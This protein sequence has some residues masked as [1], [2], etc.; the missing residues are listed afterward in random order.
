MVL[1]I[2]LASMFGCTTMHTMHQPT[3]LAAKEQIQVGDEITVWTKSGRSIQLKVT[4]VSEDALFG[5]FKAD[6]KKYKIPIAAIERI[7][8]GRVN[9]WKTG[10]AVV[11]IAFVLLVLIVSTMD[12]DFAPSF[13]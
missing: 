9:P 13:D 11:G 3:G 12:L 10:F 8:Y 6:G 7:E 2:S 5:I 1:L 4:N